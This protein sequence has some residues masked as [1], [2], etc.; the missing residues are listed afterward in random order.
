MN[1]ELQRRLNFH[2]SARNTHDKINFGSGFVGDWRVDRS[3]P[4]PPSPGAFRPITARDGERRSLRIFDDRQTV[5]PELV[6]NKLSTLHLI[7]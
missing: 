2:V 1:I 4:V 3:V 7:H 5:T 6:R